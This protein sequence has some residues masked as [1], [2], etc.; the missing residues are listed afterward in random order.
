MTADEV[1]S[2]KGGK[3]RGGSLTIV[4]CSSVNSIVL[5]SVSEVERFHFKSFASENS[6]G[7][8][9]SNNI[10]QIKHL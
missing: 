1:G 7:A 6:I 8:V 9:Q 5:V 2:G 4:I 3:E 10:L